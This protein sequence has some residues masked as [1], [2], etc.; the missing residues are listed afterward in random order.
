MML[1]MAAYAGKW[2]AHPDF[3]KPYQNNAATLIKNVSLLLNAAERA[4]VVI[5][6]NPATGS[7]VSGEQYGGFRPQACPIGAPQSAHK[8]GMAVDVYDP[9]NKLDAWINDGILT[10]YQLYREAPESTP[11]WCHLTTRPPR[12][13]RRTFKP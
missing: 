4:G 8:T 13:G 12:S 10:Q 11:G 3:T 5:P 2:L 1:T 9:E 7:Q 6:T